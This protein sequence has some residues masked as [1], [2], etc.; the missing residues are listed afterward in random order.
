MYNIDIYIVLGMYNSVEN[1]AGVSCRQPASSDAA[2][3]D[4]DA[5]DYVDDALRLC[6][7]IN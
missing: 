4:D 1:K 7:Y 6:C 5:D 2:D 3:N